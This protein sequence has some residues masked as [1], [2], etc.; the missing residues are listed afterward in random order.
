MRKQWS[1]LTACFQDH[2]DSSDLHY[3]AGVVNDELADSEKAL[4][5]FKNVLLNPVFIKMR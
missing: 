3:L 4:E 2:P 5:H 1:L